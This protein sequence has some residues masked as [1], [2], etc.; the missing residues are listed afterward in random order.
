MTNKSSSGV[1]YGVVAILVIIAFV[2]GAGV[3]VGGFIFATGGDGQASRSPQE[4]IA[5]AESQSVE[6]DTDTE[7]QADEQ[8][9]E[10]DTESDTDTNA[11]ADAQTEED[12]TTEDSTTTAEA[13]EFNIVTEQSSASFTLEEDLRGERVTVVGT[14]PDVGGTI[15]VNLSD[16]TASSVGTIA[17]NARTIAT[18]DDFRNRAI[19]SRILLSAQ[20]TYEF[21][22]FEPTSLSNFSAESVSVG[23]TIT[24][25]ITGNLTITDVTQ[26]VTFNTSVTVDSETQISG[27]A[28][29]NALYA[30]YG[31]V[32]PDVPSVANVT[33]DVDL[34][35]TFV[36]TA[37]TEES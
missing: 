4:A 20:E 1:S 8:P 9:E 13:V 3:G 24:F 18:D 19:R 15:S 6:A 37:G 14:T 23:D 16:P 26:E 31:L 21:I 27:T 36:A 11:D 12:T 25:D 2:V 28:T 35:I 10:A 33:D 17:I 32:I 34:A 22:F 29:A 7:N 5:Q 30:D